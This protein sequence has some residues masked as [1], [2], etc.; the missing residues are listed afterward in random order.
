MLAG[1]VGRGSTQGRDAR[2]WNF[3]PGL[4]AT[5]PSLPRQPQDTAR[6]RPRD[7]TQQ[8]RTS[9]GYGSVPETAQT[10]LGDSQRAEI[11]RRRG[12]QLPRQPEAAKPELARQEARE[13]YRTDH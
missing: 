6:R 3:H 8:T 4:L 10:G 5:L 7:P 9:A 11:Y 13:G 1:P 12:H 2:G